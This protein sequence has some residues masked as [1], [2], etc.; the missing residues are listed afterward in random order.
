MLY[1]AVLISE[2]QRNFCCRCLDVIWS[3]AVEWRGIYR[4]LILLGYRVHNMRRS[5]CCGNQLP[6]NLQRHGCWVHGFRKAETECCGERIV[7]ECYSN[8]SIITT[9]TR[10][11]WA[12]VQLSNESSQ[13]LCLFNNTC[14]HHLW[15]LAQNG[16]F[17]PSSVHLLFS[18][19]YRQNVLILFRDFFFQKE[20]SVERPR[21]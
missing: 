1:S 7:L 3:M 15:S 6:P 4:H 8:V 16:I 9:S 13:Q 18:C 2:D 12:S 5:C 20:K 10:P 17:W 14:C 11:F 19:S 21:C